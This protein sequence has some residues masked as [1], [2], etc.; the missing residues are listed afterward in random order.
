[1][2]DYVR[3][4]DEETKLVDAIVAKV[5]SSNHA[6]TASEINRA[7]WRRTGGG[8][9]GRAKV[10]AIIAKLV[11]LDLF[12]EVQL[13]GGRPGKRAMRYRYVG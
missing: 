2:T 5:A 6:M 13:V 7:M 10:D 3:P 8:V 1:M 4:T 9:E 12:G 11:K